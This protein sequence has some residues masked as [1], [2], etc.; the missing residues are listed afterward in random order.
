MINPVRALKKKHLA[1]LKSEHFY[2]NAGYALAAAK[3]AEEV[4]RLQEAIERNRKRR[5]M[6]EIH[7]RPGSGKSSPKRIAR[8]EKKLDSASLLSEVMSD[9][10]K[11]RNLQA[12]KLLFKRKVKGIV[13][14]FKRK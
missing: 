10:T 8:I 3:K 5:V 6:H 12:R 11:M 7:G 9:T 4:Q 1:E 13:R 14:K 2:S